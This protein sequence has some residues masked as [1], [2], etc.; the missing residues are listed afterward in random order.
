M[1]E[2]LSLS[3]YE[4]TLADKL[5]GLTEFSPGVTSVDENIYN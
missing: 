2:R 4:L 3:V 1:A 5:K